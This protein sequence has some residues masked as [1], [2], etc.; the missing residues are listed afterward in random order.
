MK[1]F[2]P[3]LGIAAALTGKTM[4]GNQCISKEH[5]WS[6][7]SLSGPQGDCRGDETRKVRQIREGERGGQMWTHS[8]SAFWCA[9]LFC[10]WGCQKLPTPCPKPFFEPQ[11]DVENIWPLPKHWSRRQ[12]FVFSSHS[13]RLS[14]WPRAG[15]NWVTSS[16]CPT[17]LCQQVGS[18]TVSFPP[19]FCLTYRSHKLFM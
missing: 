10:S 17:A 19:V 9:L 1:L 12:E 6:T 18:K 8:L 13:A 4:P 16:H 2:F 14:G 5:L 15:H 7:A 11:F 3:G